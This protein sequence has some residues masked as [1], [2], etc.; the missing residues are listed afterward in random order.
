[1]L[2]YSTFSRAGIF[3]HESKP[4]MLNRNFEIVSPH[5]FDKI[6]DVQI[7]VDGLTLHTKKPLLYI[8]N[9]L[10]IAIQDIENHFPFEIRKIRNSGIITSF[11]DN[12][13]IKFAVGSKTAFVNGKN[14]ILQTP[15]S[16]IFD[17]IYIPFVFFIQFNDYKVQYHDKNVQVTHREFKKLN[18]KEG[19]QYT[20]TE[21]ENFNLAFLLPSHWKRIKSNE[22]G[23]WNEY[24]KYRL[25]ISKEQISGGDILLFLQKYKH[26]IIAEDPNIKFY[27]E[28][29]LNI[30]NNMYHHFK[31]EKVDKELTII[32]DVYTIQFKDEIFILAF[33]YNR[34]NQKYISSEFYDIL[35]SLHKNKVYVN[36]SE[37]HYY[38][39]N[40]F[41]DY[42]FRLE[43]AIYSNINVNGMLDFSGSLKFPQNEDILLFA[44]V[45]KEG[46]KLEF[47]IPIERVG[48][49][50]LY[51][52]SKL[53]SP[54]G[55]GKHNISIFM[56]KKKKEGYHEAENI[57]NF[58]TIN[59]SSNINKYLIPTRYV[60][61]NST[62]SNSLATILTME[63]KND[64]EKIDSIFQY[65]VQ[66]IKW[67]SHHSEKP[68]N[69]DAIVE[70]KI[71]S[72]LELNITACALL[73]N[74]GISSKIY[75]G[76]IENKKIYF[77]EYEINGKNKILDLESQILYNSGKAQ[78]IR[79]SFPFNK[80]SYFSNL[81]AEYYKSLLKGFKLLNH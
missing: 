57:L 16:R 15:V 35:F 52:N 46:E 44:V 10:M 51:Y 53:Y 61:S 66:E 14:Y 3:A 38:E 40:N 79:L 39:F 64:Y 24:S 59:L 68:N 31:Y 65:I 77:T 29:Q 37:E 62:I 13:F 5:H 54:F 32:H 25:T 47:D 6:A 27:E 72:S 55:L 18:I 17:D 28:N 48:Q 60:L 67:S 2:F 21:L 73:R 19:I 69:S 58:S 45:E 1:M 75:I 56:K 71:G 20:Y 74:L 23:V 22:F 43:K 36:V 11:Y 33:Q 50:R 7:Q 76:E 42:N 78:E 49:E 30:G 81:D 41:Y 9:V 12:N 26:D 70:N 8:D 34:E 4:K 80:Y 63:T